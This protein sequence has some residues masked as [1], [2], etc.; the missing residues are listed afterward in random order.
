MERTADSAPW[1]SNASRSRSAVPLGRSTLPEIGKHW[2]SDGSLDDFTSS[3]PSSVSG[4]AFD[5]WTA[6]ERPSSMIT[7]TARMK[8]LA[9]RTVRALGVRVSHAILS[10]FTVAMEWR[11]E[12]RLSKPGDSATAWILL[13][14]WTT[15]RVICLAN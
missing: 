1:V 2:L 12:I 9:S 5:H 13:H 6:I 14:R 4:R 15:R 10:A 7:L 11:R 8:H 3:P